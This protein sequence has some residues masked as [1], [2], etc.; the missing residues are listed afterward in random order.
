MVLRYTPGW[1]NE[2]Q[3]GTFT[4][5]DF[6]ERLFEKEFRGTDFDSGRLLE[7][8]ASNFYFRTPYF[9][10]HYIGGNPEAIQARLDNPRDV[11]FYITQKRLATGAGREVLLTFDMGVEEIN[12]LWPNEADLN[13]T[14]FA[15]AF[16]NP[17]PAWATD[18]Y[19]PNRAIDWGN[20]S[21]IRDYSFCGTEA[22]I[23]GLEGPSAEGRYDQ[24]L[25]AEIGTEEYEVLDWWGEE[26]RDIIFSWRQLRFFKCTNNP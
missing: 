25:R 6:L 22:S 18:F 14:N 15:L 20:A 7:V 23:Y 9:I 16:E 26:N 3:L 19:S 21:M 4:H 12:V 1:W 2:Y 11:F 5:L 10:A 17:D 24:V 13:P 8:T